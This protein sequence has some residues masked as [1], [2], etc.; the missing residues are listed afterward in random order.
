M[1][2]TLLALALV[3]ATLALPTDLSSQKSAAVAQ[4]NFE[5]D[6]SG[7]FPY[8]RDVQIAQEATVKDFDGPFGRGLP[9]GVAFR[10]DL[11]GTKPFVKRD[12]QDA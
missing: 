6:S 9:N 2:Y 3:S 5:P 8:Q 1:R 10:R 11:T 7:S 12:N 4:T